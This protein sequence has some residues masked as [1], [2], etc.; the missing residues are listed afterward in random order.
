MRTPVQQKGFTLL[1]LLMVCLLIS[2]SLALSIPSLRNS[3]VTDQLAT[4]SRKVI[5]LVK[6][7]RAKAVANQEA[8]LIFYDSAERKLWYQKAGGEESSEAHSS[9]VLPPDIH[10]QAIKQA[11]GSSAPD[12]M[13]TGIWVSRQGYMDKTGIQL[14][15]KTNE[16]LNL[17]ISPFLPTIKITEG[18]IE[19]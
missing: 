9:I 4:G 6:S 3:I 7:C 8:Y 16:S 14:V 15:N 10:I 18:A 13:E 1:E 5:S 2:I 19:F 11:S 12:I 17:L